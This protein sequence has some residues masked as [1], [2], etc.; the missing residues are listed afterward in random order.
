MFFGMGR[1]LKPDLLDP[2]HNKETPYVLWFC[3]PG[4]ELK[5]PSS[6]EIR[7]NIRKSNEIPHPGS[8]PE[9][10]KKYSKNT[11]SVIF[12]PFRVFFCIFVCIFGSDPGWGISEVFRIFFV[13]PGLRGF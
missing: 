8:G 1:T 11:K 5:N 13:F 7:K 4:I 6:P 3:V 10:A 9:N 12:G 2:E